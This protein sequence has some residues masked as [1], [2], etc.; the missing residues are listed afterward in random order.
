LAESPEK[1]R[2]SVAADGREIEVAPKEDAGSP[3]AWQAP[4]DG[5]DGEAVRIRFENRA[6]ESVSVARPRLEGTAEPRPAPLP[7]PRSAEA[8]NVILYLI[9]ALRPITSPP[10]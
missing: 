9:D 4:I 7:G 3:G 2:I 10:T 6:G 8:P 5:L 1:L